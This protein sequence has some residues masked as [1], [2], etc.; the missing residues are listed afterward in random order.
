MSTEKRKK[1][2]TSGYGGSGHYLASNT[3]EKEA[4][5][6]QSTMREKKERGH[7]F[8]CGER[9]EISARSRENATAFLYSLRRMK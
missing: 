1:K 6:R 2:H 8:S 3:S 7:Y 9:S 4:N 5:S